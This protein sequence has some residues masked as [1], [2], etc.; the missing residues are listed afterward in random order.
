MQSK[1][2]FLLVI[3]C[4]VVG[5]AYVGYSGT[6]STASCQP[7]P[8]AMQVP[9]TLSSGHY[10]AAPRRAGSRGCDYTLIYGCRQRKILYT[11]GCVRDIFPAESWREVLPVE[12]VSPH[13][14]RLNYRTDQQSYHWQ[15]VEINLSG[16]PDFS[17]LGRYWSTGNFW[18]NK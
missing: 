17:P 2:V 16:T 14:L 15:T 10:V 12:W 13:I 11:L 1:W 7:L 5:V 8:D 6:N 9:G 3:F 18:A 4:L